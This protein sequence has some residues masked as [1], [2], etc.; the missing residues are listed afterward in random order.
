MK[1]SSFFCKADPETLVSAAVT[2]SLEI[3]AGLSG[4]ELTGYGLTAFEFT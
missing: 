1:K 3:K 4:S 2:G